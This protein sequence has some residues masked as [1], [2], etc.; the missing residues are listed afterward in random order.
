MEGRCPGVQY[1]LAALLIISSQSLINLCLVS[2]HALMIGFVAGGPIPAFG[3][4]AK[5]FD[6][7]LD[8][9][10]YIV[11]IQVGGISL[12]SVFCFES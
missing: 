6:V 12:Y 10:A 4:F 1:A 3:A 11:S 7:S 2:F 8:A 9:A 5:D